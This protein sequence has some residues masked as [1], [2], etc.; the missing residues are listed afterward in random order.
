MKTVWGKKLLGGYPGLFHTASKI[1]KYIPESKIYVEP[2]SG[3]G[4][5]VELKH[6]KI[7]LNDKS[8]YA[9]EECRKKFPTAIVENMDFEDT[10][11]KYDSEDTFF[12]IDP[13]WIFNVYD[14]REESFCDRDIKSYYSK[15]LKLVKNIKGDFIICASNDEQKMDKILTNTA[16]FR[17]YNIKQIESDKGVIFGKKARTLLVSNLPLGDKDELA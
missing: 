10:I 5:T 9:N 2:F 6:D 7:V 1:V 8:E 11:N 12:L 4:R 3:L 15:I 13:P 14:V 17:G 16:K